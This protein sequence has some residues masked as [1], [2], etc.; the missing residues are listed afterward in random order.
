MSYSASPIDDIAAY[1]GGSDMH[2]TGRAARAAVAA[3]ALVAG[4]VVS[5]AAPAAAA[6]ETLT[7]T[8]VADTWVNSALPSTA[9]GSSTSLTAD[10]SPVSVSHLRFDVSTLAGKTVTGVRL[11]M[12]QVDAS[13]T[14]GRVSRTSNTTWSESATTWN[15]RPVLDGAVLAT[16]GAVSSSTWYEVALDPAALQAP[17][18]L[19]L[20]VDSTSRDGS[21][22]AS[23]ETA[24]P[25]S[26]V[27]TVET[28]PT[29]PAPP[30]ADA[31]GLSAV[32][33]ADAGSSEPTYY[34]ANHRLATT[35]GGRVLAVHGRH[36]SGV[37]LTWRDAGGAWQTASTGE[38]TTGGVL[39]GTGTGDWPAS[40][41]V[42]NDGAQHAWVVWARPT[43][44]SSTVRPLQLRRLTELDAPGGP[45]L[46]PLVT[47]DAPVGGAWK[48]DAGVELQPDGT[49]RVAVSYS[50]A[51]GGGAFEVVTGWLD[52]LSTATPALSGLV[53]LERTT[54]STHYASLVSTSVGLRAV[55]RTGSG[56]ARLQVFGHDTGTAPTQWSLRGTGPAMPNGASPTG[57]AL[58]GG[59]L[60]VSFEDDLTNHVTNVLR[61]SA[62]GATIT[63]ILRQSGLAQPAVAGNG[64]SA[65]LVGVRGSDGAL[66][67]RTWSA[68]TWTADRVEVAPGATGGV[69]A[70]PNVLREAGGTL[71]VLLEGH[72]TS[73][74]RSSVWA[75]QRSL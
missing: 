36:S 15:T 46:G 38:S 47:L 65:V 71:R 9:Y 6:T 39:T 54:T 41:V 31:D 48:A 34:A 55:A 43:Y 22:W 26:L 23:R 52:G 67:S 29:A 17:D 53:V 60:V 61:I 27:V 72:G 64:A 14:G 3:F 4:L 25:P 12:R 63:S 49:S 7:L 59:E 45:H 74:S 28:T 2:R 1:A 20:A 70:Y 5:S 11:R 35:A 50:R 56:G 69:L 62:S 73:T 68:G 75:V 21:R 19:A 51:V 66:V 40:I 16:Y 10:A 24:T 18:V 37:Q 30:P 32:A 42:A 8:A 33:A 57:A 44:S 58:D 13:N